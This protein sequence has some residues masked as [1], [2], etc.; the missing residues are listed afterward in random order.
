MV[1]CGRL[2]VRVV[3]LLYIAENKRAEARRDVNLIS[4]PLDKLTHQQSMFLPISYPFPENWQMQSG[5]IAQ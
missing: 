1:Q 4:R 5:R 3:E 2:V